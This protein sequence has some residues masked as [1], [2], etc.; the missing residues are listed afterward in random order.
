MAAAPP[1]RPDAQPEATEP[2]WVELQSGGDHQFTV[3][4]TDHEGREVSFTTP[5]V[6]VPDSRAE[7]WKALSRVGTD[8]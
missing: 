6:F 7:D 5:L 3:L 1:D 2:F 4:A 8:R